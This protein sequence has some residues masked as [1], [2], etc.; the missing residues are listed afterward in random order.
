M[1]VLVGAGT[2]VA[3]RTV[4]VKV[5]LNGVKEYFG[6]LLSGHL[7]CGRGDGPSAGMYTCWAVAREASN[8]WPRNVSRAISVCIACA[9]LS[10]LVTWKNCDKQR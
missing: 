6:L 5:K 10:E 7:H 3:Y 1:V 2:D 4:S 9:K 8:S